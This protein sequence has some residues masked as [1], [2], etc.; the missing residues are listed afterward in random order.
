M[1]ELKDNVNHPNHYTAGNIEC[2]DALKAATEGLTG[3]EAVC[4]AN[5]IKYLWRWKH[6]N[7]AE[8]LKKAIWYIERLI[9]EITPAGTAP[10]HDGCKECLFESRTELEYPCCTCKGSSH[11]REREYAIRADLWTPV[12][13]KLDEPH[14]E[15]CRERL[16]REH[17]ERVDNSYLGGCRGCPEHYGYVEV[18]GSCGSPGGCRVCWDSPVETEAP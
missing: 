4:T 7:G 15:T 13:P 3:I 14:R 8:D 12:E 5:A 11:P 6:K 16:Q 2:I 1:A 9:K 18:S 10:D 17:P